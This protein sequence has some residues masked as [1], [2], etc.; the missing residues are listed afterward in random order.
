MACF[1]R[2]SQEQLQN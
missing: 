2:G 1:E